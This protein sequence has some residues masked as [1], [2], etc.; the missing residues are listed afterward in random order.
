MVM[1]V[2]KS[3]IWYLVWWP[4]VVWGLGVS[5]LSWSSS[6]LLAFPLSVVRAG[7]KLLS[8]ALGADVLREELASTTERLARVEM[9]LAQSHEVR[10]YRA[11]A[12][13]RRE[14]ALFS[15]PGQKTSPGYPIIL[16]FSLRSCH[17]AIYSGFMSR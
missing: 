14:N 11:A 12:P 4:W 10:T 8:K 9:E 5:S 1:E 15:P 6:C 7:P 13:R 16:H 2:V 17:R 3:G